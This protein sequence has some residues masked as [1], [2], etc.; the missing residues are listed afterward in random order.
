MAQGFLQPCNENE[1]METVGMRYLKELVSRSF[2]QD[3]E[4]KIG[5][6]Y[7]FKMHDLMHDLALSVSKNEC[8]TVTSSKQVIS[9]KVRHLS[10]V[11]ANIVRGVL[12]NLIVNFDHLRTIFFPFYEERPSQSFV[13]SCISKFS[14][15]RMLDLRNSDIEVLPKSVGNLKQLRYL[16][17]ACNLK[18]KKLPNSICKL[19][20]LQTLILIRCEELQQLPRDIGHL[21]NLRMLI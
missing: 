17:L 8:F 18:M 6:F 14:L 1:E 2:F 12:P 5:Y 19:Q 21:I 4:Q 13:K 16:D 3:F 9:R 20:S 15:L 7:T 11:D 10:F